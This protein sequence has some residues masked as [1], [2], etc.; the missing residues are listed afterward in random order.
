[1]ILL[2]LADGA[3]TVGWLEQKLGQ[4]Q[5]QISHHLAKLRLQEVVLCRRVGRQAY[6]SVALPEM[7]WLLEH[8]FEIFPEVTQET[9]ISDRTVPVSG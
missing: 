6:Y 7:V 3:K 9:R 2:L 5:A 8:L 4:R 1:M